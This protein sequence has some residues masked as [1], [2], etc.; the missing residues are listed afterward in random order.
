MVDSDY[1]GDNVDRKSTTGFVIRSYG[2]VIDWKTHK[3]STVT[4]CSTFAEYIAMSD[5][6]T[7]ILFIR[8]LLCESFNVKF[9]KPIKMY[10]DNSRVIA[11]AKFGNF[12]KASK[13]IEVQYHYINKSYENG[14][15]DAVKID[16]EFN[17]AD[18]L[19]KSLD[20]T[21]FLKNLKA[22][23]VI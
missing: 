8:N 22:L 15:I 14:I 18:M 19:T 6:V 1:A 2:N 16:S 21:K 11:I 13:H 7:E 9:D 5:A 12:T 23:R 3:Q 4:K 10:E 17:L 20:K